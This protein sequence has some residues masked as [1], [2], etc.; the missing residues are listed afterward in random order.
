MD[1][2]KTKLNI[3]GANKYVWNSP[4]INADNMSVENIVMIQ[5]KGGPILGSC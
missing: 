2:T 4:C 3:K 1:E 5:K